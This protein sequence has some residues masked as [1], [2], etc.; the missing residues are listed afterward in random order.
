M[1]NGNYRGSGSLGI[2]LKKLPGIGVL[3]PQL[4]FSWEGNS[5]ATGCTISQSSPREDAPVVNGFRR[6]IV[7][8]LP[9]P[10][11][12]AQVSNITIGSYSAS[13]EAQIKAPTRE[14]PN[15]G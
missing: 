2:A 11:S 4:F 1:I 12:Y 9:V 10:W 14:G 6:H 8:Y 7:V 3:I 15:A 13:G 5:E